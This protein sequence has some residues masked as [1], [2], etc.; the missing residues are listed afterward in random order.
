MFLK[1]QKRLDKWWN[2][3]KGWREGKLQSMVD[4]AKTRDQKR[5]AQK[6]YNEADR[7]VQHSCRR[8]KRQWMEEHTQ[9]AEEAPSKLEM[10]SLNSITKFF[11]EK[12]RNTISKPVRGNEGNLIL[13]KKGQTERWREHFKDFLNR[14]THQNHIQLEASDL[15][16]ICTGPITR[17]AI[18]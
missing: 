18:K 15:L 17:I 14:E 11:S 1:R 4:N 9:E 7:K 16:P 6:Q 3:E 12:R 10:K 2:V 13:T 5:K 8:Y